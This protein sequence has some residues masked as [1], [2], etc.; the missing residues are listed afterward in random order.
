MSYHRVNWENYPSPITPINATNLNIMD[1]GIKDIEERV[2]DDATALAAE[3]ITRASLTAHNLL[4]NKAISQTINGITF[5]VNDDKSVTVSTGAGGATQQTSFIIFE[6]VA[7]WKNMVMTGTPAGASGTTY[8]LYAYDTVTSGENSLRGDS[9][10][11][12]S[13][14]TNGN[15]IRVAIRIRSGVIITTPITF[16]PMICLATDTDATYRPYAMTNKQ[17]TDNK[18]GWDDNSKLGAKNLLPC[19]MKSHSRSGVSATV[20]ADGTVTL[21]NTA[22]ASNIFPIADSNLSLKAGTYTFTCLQE[23]GSDGTFKAWVSNLGDYNNYFDYGDGVTFTVPNDRSNVYVGIGFA[24]GQVF[25]NQVF[26]PMIR[27]A[28][29]SDSTYQ[30]YAETNK[31][32]TDNVTDIE[33]AIAPLEIGTAS[34]AYAKGD[35]LIMSD[36]L[37]K[38]TTAIVSGATL[39]VGTNITQTSVAEELELNNIQLELTGISTNKG[40]IEGV[41]TNVIPLLTR[42][43]MKCSGVVKVPGA[44]TF[45]FTVLRISST[46]YYGFFHANDRVFTAISS[47]GTVTAYQIVGTAI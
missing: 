4:P 5:T 17:L 11:V 41:F 13:N 29:D 18:V 28:S 14:I 22:T 37:Y 27:L 21:N 3:V 8:D 47:S 6:D 2:D 43:L 15:I 38:A 24:S 39:T 26:K 34:Q 7:S 42:D 36:K 32:L 1:K 45:G 33:T 46:M 9:N 44:N 16:Y 20:N 23:P 12:L 25:N 19:T 35:Y 10:V 40:I 31:Q 30:P